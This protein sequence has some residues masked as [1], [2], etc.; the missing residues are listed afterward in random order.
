MS[1]IPF[2]H[3][4]GQT[5]AKFLEKVCQSTDILFI[6]HGSDSKILGGGRMHGFVYTFLL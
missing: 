4:I 5:V 6:Y 3:C 2:L 1:E